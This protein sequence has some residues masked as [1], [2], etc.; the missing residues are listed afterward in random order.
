MLASISLHRSS[1]G[2]ERQPLMYGG[3]AAAPTSTYL[4]PP[5]G[6][7]PPAGVV[8]VP[9]Q[10]HAAQGPVPGQACPQ[11]GY[12]QQGYPQQ[13]AGTVIHV[14]PDQ[15][16]QLPAAGQSKEPEPAQL[17]SAPAQVV[18]PDGQLEQ[19]PGK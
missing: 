10:T 14:S 17:Q 3:H 13:V 12:P 8:V 4:I 2:G 11:Q 19:W 9:Q 15:V 1:A 18:G 5:A 6:G 7:H 16:T